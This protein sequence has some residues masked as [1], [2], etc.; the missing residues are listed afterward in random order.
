M[1]K[2]IEIVSIR[3]CSV[4]PA[5][6]HFTDL[7]IGALLSLKECMGAVKN[8]VNHHDADHGDD[9][10]YHVSRVLVGGELSG[11]V[12]LISLHERVEQ[13]CVRYSDDLDSCDVDV[14][15]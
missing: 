5:C 7:V 2:I 1:I 8:T 3:H 9:N 10:Q 15:V 6:F 14:Q 4:C 12:T 11:N 13:E